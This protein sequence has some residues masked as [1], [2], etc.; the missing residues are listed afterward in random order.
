[1]ALSGTQK[2]LMQGRSGIARSGATRSGYFAPLNVVITIDNNGIPTDVSRYV[3]YNGWSLS[4]NLNDEIDT[5]TL[6]L[7]PSMPFV[8]VTRA[9]VK[10]GFG[11]IGNLQ[12]A[13]IV[14]TVQ[15]TRKPGPDPREW[16]DLTCVDWTAILD[17]HLVVATYPPQS[18]TT[19]IRDLIARFTRGNISTAGV[20]ANLPSVPGMSIV[21]ER[22]STIL[23]RLTNKIGG[24]FWLDANRVLRAWSSTMPSPIQDQP[25]MPLT[26]TLKT[27]KTFRS[28]EDASQQRTRLFVEGQQTKTRL[29]VPEYPNIP[30][31]FTLS[32]PIEDSHLV[33]QGDS[34]ALDR[35]TRI[36][37]QLGQ[38]F[39]VYLPT[40]DASN[41]S[42]GTILTADAPAAAPDLF[43]ETTASFP[44]V[45]GWAQVA[46]QIV[47]VSVV[48]ETQLRLEP[49]P[50]YGSLQAPVSIGAQIVVLPWLQFAPQDRTTASDPLFAPAGGMVTQ[51]DSTPV[52]LVMRQED[53]AAAATLAVRE[54]SDGYY[55]HL[56]QDGRFAEDG[57]RARAVAELAD[58]AGPLIAY[59]WETEDLN[60]APG[61]MQQ[62]RFTGTPLTT[63]VRITNVEIT[64]IAPKHPPRRQVRATKIQ[65]AGVMDTWVDDPR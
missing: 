36:G 60:A 54:G 4:L 23:R 31:D 11:A 39:Y 62:I 9:Q 59:E 55:E 22:P 20:A 65:T 58:F 21:N 52:V 26:D 42:P 10:I 1:M 34:N 27:L 57:A 46:G 64:P 50:G 24:G 63:D 13:G 5:A 8:P 3:A 48:S 56:V 53:A 16:Y 45:G 19:T 17:A 40:A 18:V 6:A 30:T 2:A 15:K 51:P 29:G 33:M 7:L 37:T 25:P 35:M 14:L 49:S 32:I 61:R 44:A 12:F 47:K 38:A 43:V 41:N 28:T